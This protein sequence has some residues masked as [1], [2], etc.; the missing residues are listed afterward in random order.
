MTPISS[1]NLAFQDRDTEDKD[2]VYSIVKPLAPG[3]GTIEYVSH[4]FTPITSFSQEDI[5]NNRIMYRPPPKELGAQERE[6]FFTFTGKKKLH[7]YFIFHVINTLESFVREL[8]KSF[9]CVLVSDGSTNYTKE[10]RFF[11][12]V[13][14]VNNEPP[15]FA[16][17]NAPL[18]VT[19][20]GSAPLGLPV[21]GVMDP[22][23]SLEDLKFT[24]TVMPNHGQMEKILNTSKVYMRQG[25]I[26]DFMG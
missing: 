21:L 2:I 3:E 1:T 19:R 24:L 6:F 8:Q 18:Q 23:T 20:G 22:D 16:Y 25:K 10:E 13:I 11:I 5:N 4:P 14:P 9:V 15:Q 17:R 12:R 7:L 26:K